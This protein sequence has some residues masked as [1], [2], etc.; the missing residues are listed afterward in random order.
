MG[1]PV[2]HILG[3]QRNGVNHVSMNMG[4]FDRA[5]GPVRDTTYPTYSD[6][7][8]DW[9]Q[10][11]N[12]QSV[13]LLFTWE[14]VQS[15]LGGPVPATGPGYSDY[16]ADLTSVVTRLLARDIYVILAPWQYNT[17][18]ADTDIVYDDAAFTSADFAD[19]WG[20]FATAINGMTGN[21]QRV[22]FDLL[23]E[24]HTHVESGDKLGDIGISLTGWFTVFVPGMA[25]T[26]ADSFTTNGSSIAWLS[27]LDPQNN[28]AVT[29]HCYAGLGSASPTVLRDACAALVRWA[30]S[31]A[32]KVN[33][34]E[35]AIDAGP[36]GR[37]VYHSTSPI[38]QAQWADWNRFC[39]ANRDVLIGW[40]WWGNSAPGWW[41]Q[42]DS[43]D[44]NHWG[45][46]LDN[47]T[48]QTIFMELITVL[49]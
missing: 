30:R 39:V 5:A 22:A 45:L 48:T 25:Y 6:T 27:L 49:P 36:N 1:Y 43:A 34:G 33:V 24:P 16:W 14:A 23:N 41:D 21:D 18:S 47:G 10:A 15:T 3:S 4:D 44:G 35:I 32:I 29:V 17:S 31:N 8:L 12:V 19:F 11:K 26:A 40:N 38:A 7:L 37:P 28:I 46:T 2:D 9:Y 20:K 13:R 42:G